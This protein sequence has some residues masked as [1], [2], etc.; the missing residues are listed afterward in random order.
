MLVLI[1][2]RCSLWIMNWSLI[3]KHAENQIGQYLS[4]L[5]QLDIF[6][7]PTKESLVIVHIFTIHVVHRTRKTG[8]LQ[9]S[10]YTMIYLFF[11]IVLKPQSIVVPFLQSEHFYH[12]ICT[13]YTVDINHSSPVYHQLQD[14]SKTVEPLSTTLRFINF[15]RHAFGKRTVIQI[16]HCSSAFFLCDE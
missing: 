5:L 8:R 14:K 16:S 2:Q 13:K 15:K 7:K 9:V 6:P 1:I 4:H 3:F 10:N 11:V 12:D